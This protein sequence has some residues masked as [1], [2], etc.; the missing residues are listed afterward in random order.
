MLLRVCLLEAVVAAGCFA[1]PAV[2]KVEP[3]NWWVGHTR[4]PVQVLLTGAD[5]KGAVVSTAAKG[6]R[7]EVRRTSE[8]GYYL[9][10]YLTIEPAAKVGKYRFQG[11][12]ASGSGEF[13]FPLKSPLGPKGRFQGFSEDNVIY[14]TMPARSAN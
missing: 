4:N 13:E 2:T 3:P 12:G 7:I 1:A 9:F 10:A 8:N 14:L 6:F 11:K 5:L